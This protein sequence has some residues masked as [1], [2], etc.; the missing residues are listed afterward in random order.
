VV[1]AGLDGAGM[2]LGLSAGLGAVLVLVRLPAWRRPSMV[3]RLAPHLRDAPRAS[4]LLTGTA[5]ATGGWC[6]VLALLAPVTRERSALRHALD[7]LASGS[8]GTTRRLRQAGSSRSLEQFR[9]EQVVCGVLGLLAGV[10]AAAVAAARGAPAVPLTGL[11]LVAGLA[12]VLA[13]DWWLSRAVA[14]RAERIVAEF[15]TV[16]E[17]LALPVGAGEGAVGALDRVASSSSDELAGELRRTLADARAGAPLVAALEGLAAR[18]S[19]PALGRFVDG[20]AVA[21]ERGMPLAEVLRAQAQDVRELSRR[22]LMEAGGQ[23]EVQ[24]MV[25]TNM[26]LGYPLTRRGGGSVLTA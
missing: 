6:P 25:P 9:A 20:L 5:A 10:G 11:V 4:R 19:V 1:V 16:A 14:R 12:G 26:Q 15:P 13:R 18:T 17:L 3:E 24:M 8:E 23:E 22:Q 21:L 2:L 7:R